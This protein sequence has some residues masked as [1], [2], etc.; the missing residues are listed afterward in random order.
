MSW[1]L[2]RKDI[3]LLVRNPVTYLGI[4]IMVALV[5]VTVSTFY[6][7]YGNVRDEKSSVVYD[8]DGTIED[9]YIPTP[10]EILYQNAMQDLR[11][12]LISD[13]NFSEEKADKEIQKIQESG[14]SI[15]QIAEYFKDNYDYSLNGVRSSF[16]LYEY[17]WATKEELQEYLDEA[18]RDKTYT[19]CFAY[20]YSEYLGIGA[21]LFTVVVFA[22]ILAKDLKKDI[23]A[24]IHAK[25]ICSR[26][27][28]LGKMLAGVGFVYAVI[29]PLTLIINMI[30]MRVG[31]SYG[32]P[33]DF[34]DIWKRVIVLDFPS[35]LL[36]GCL[37]M[38]IALL[39][40]SITPAIPAL[41]LYF[42]S[43]NMGTYDSSSGYIYRVSPF[44][45]FVRFPM[46]FS[47]LTMPR[48]ALWNVCFAC[49]L[50]AVLLTVSLVLWERRR[51]G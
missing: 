45:F 17:K 18:F 44:A 27:Y 38:F 48:G 42:V 46:L 23:Y 29:I 12:G 7:L 39:F 5:V 8:S 21:I 20:K 11:Q 34:W 31:K 16:A 3:G 26:D 1:K 19:G 2:A 25:P 37:M 36:T 24:L 32:F 41:L 14:W 13:C 33:V 15:D 51:G 35:I 4:I 47:E 40:R 30:A 49:A 43:S 9:G 6:D 28:I 22:L 10:P 50:S